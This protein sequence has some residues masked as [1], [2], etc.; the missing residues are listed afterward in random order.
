VASVGD[1]DDVTQLRRE[2]HYLRLGDDVHSLGLIGPRKL[3]EAGQVAKRFARLARKSGAEHA[4]TIV[5]AP[6]RQAANGEE[7][8]AV[9]SEATQA[10]VVAE[11]HGIT[12]ERAHT[13][14]G[15]TL[16]LAATARRLRTDLEVGRGGLREGAA[17]ALARAAAAAA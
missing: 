17:L 8:V 10:P 16:V 9:L 2:R 6:G 13:L 15:G 1:D 5:T 11:P 12:P 14:L 3:K 7:L 4:E